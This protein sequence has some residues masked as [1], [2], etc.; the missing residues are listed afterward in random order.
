MGCELEANAASFGM[1]VFKYMMHILRTRL[2]LEWKDLTV[3]YPLWLT[4]VVMDELYYVTTLVVMSLACFAV[5][6]IT[7]TV[8]TMV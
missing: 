7:G 2:I 6:M 5:G 4:H 3:T 1:N 8:W